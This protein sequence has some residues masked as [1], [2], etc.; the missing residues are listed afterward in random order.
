[1]AAS[2]QPLSGQNHRPLLLAVIDS[3]LQHL[4]YDH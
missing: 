4:D 2:T 3:R 1:L